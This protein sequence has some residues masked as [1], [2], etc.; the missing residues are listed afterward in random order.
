MKIIIIGSVVIL[1]LS[2]LW[3]II[4]ALLSGS[5]SKYENDITHLEKA[6]DCASSDDYGMYLYFLG[7]YDALLRNNWDP[8]RT[9]RVYSKLLLKYLHF[10]NEE[11]EAI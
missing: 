5:L 8:D 2:L 6:I 4:T 1:G 9:L 7:E 3:W 10:F 11:V